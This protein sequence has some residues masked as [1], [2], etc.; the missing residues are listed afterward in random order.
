MNNIIIIYYI[1]NISREK[2]CNIYKKRI[3]K[4]INVFH[5]PFYFLSYVFL[6]K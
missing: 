1:L 4:S 2:Y 3:E 6:S 5:A